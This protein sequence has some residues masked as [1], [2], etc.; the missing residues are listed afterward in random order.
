MSDRRPETFDD[1]RDEILAERPDA[2]E[3]WHAS[4]LKRAVAMALVG[5]RKRVG[6]TQIEVAKRAG[7]DKGYVSRLEGVAGGLPELDT[8]VRYALA[9]GCELR[10]GLFHADGK[11]VVD[12]LK[13]Q[14][15]ATLSRSERRATE[16]ESAVEE[17][18]ER[19]VAEA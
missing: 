15:V 18:E 1:L 5:M 17:A 13:S 16:S 10:L 8:L 7:W 3:V 19:R 12:L 6:L 9:C 2:R 11:E 4:K 14:T